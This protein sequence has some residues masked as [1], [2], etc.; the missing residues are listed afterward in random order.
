MNQVVV[1][2]DDEMVLGATCAVLRRLYPV[3]SFQ[4]PI[5]ALQ[6]L[7]GLSG[8]CIIVCDYDMPQ[9]TGI[10]VYS[11]LRPVHQKKFLL[12]TG[13]AYADS[14][15]GHLLPKPASLAQMKLAIERVLEEEKVAG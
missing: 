13:N 15:S 10:D 12:Y 6:H 5:D 14:P 2:D 1:I 9:M 4:N 8:E 3:V 11:K 7:E